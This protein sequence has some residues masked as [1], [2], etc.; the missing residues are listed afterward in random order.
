MTKTKHILSSG[1][2]SEIEQWPVK[3]V[4]KL[5]FHTEKA[6]QVGRALMSLRDLNPE[7]DPIFFT[8]NQIILFGTFEIQLHQFGTKKCDWLAEAAMH[9]L[10]GFL[11][12]EN[13]FR[14]RDS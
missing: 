10:S 7:G 13:T 6:Q 2:G 14:F 3:E 8:F 5:F 12:I 9:A 11:W 4:M 1:T